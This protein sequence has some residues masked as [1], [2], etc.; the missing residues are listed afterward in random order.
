MTWKTYSRH[1]SRCGKVGPRVVNPLGAG[2]I[3]AYCRTDDERREERRQYAIACE[4]R[5]KAIAERKAK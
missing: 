2:F 5:D 4:K 3:H 1:C